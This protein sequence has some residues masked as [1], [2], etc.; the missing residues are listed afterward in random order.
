M[1]TKPTRDS[2][3]L[4]EV[5]FQQVLEALLNDQ[6]GF[7]PRYLYRF[8]DLVESDLKSL[9]ATWPQVSVRRRRAIL[10]DIEEL[11]MGEEPQTLSF[12][13]FCR[14]TVGDDDGRVRELSVRVLTEYESDDLLPLF[15]GLLKTDADADVRAASAAALGYYVYLGELE[16]LPPGT[17]DQLVDSLIETYT[18][19]ETTSVRRKV[20]ESLGF[21]SRQEI[22]AMIETAF[23]SGNADWISSALF[24]MSRTAS[25]QWNS[26]ILEMLDNDNPDIRKEAARAAGELEVHESTDRLIELLEDGDQD[27]RMASIWSLSQIGGDGVQE[28]LELLSEETED[29]EEAGFIDDALDNLQFTEEMQLFSLMELEDDIDEDDLDEF[30]DELDDDKQ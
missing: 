30:E 26:H 4:D 28:A 12:E 5:P 10:E 13:D 18:S 7:L 27:V 8:S 22:P 6:K 15:E 14:Y 16:E 24:A 11:E 3:S 21:S 19:G 1:N 29:E 9:A 2:S 23:Y 25:S 20:L 17:L